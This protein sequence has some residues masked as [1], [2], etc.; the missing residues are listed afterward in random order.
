MFAMI[1]RLWIIEK[2]DILG[3]ADGFYNVHTRFRRLLGPSERD[4]QR[5]F[6]WSHSWSHQGSFSWTVDG[7]LT[8]KEKCHA[9]CSRPSCWGAEFDWRPSL[10]GWKPL[11]V[12]SP[13]PGIDSRVTWL[14]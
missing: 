13:G 12:G 9:G 4:I 11:L 8:V 2:C 14:G 7:S 1:S 6:G 10:L 3:F 5:I